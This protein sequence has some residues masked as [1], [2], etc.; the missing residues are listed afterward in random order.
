MSLEDWTP[1]DRQAV[2]WVLREEL[3][4][5]TGSREERIREIGNHL[6]LIEE[7]EEKIE[8]GDR[9]S[10]L[11]ALIWLKL[12]GAQVS[13]TWLIELC[14]E[15]Q[16]LR[17]AAVQVLLENDDVETD[18][19]GTELLL[20]DSEPMTLLGLDALY[21]MNFRNPEHLLMFTGFWAR[22]WGISKLVQVL[23]VMKTCEPPS[24]HVKAD[25]LL[26]FLEHDFPSVRAYIVEALLGY[27]QLPSEKPDQLA[28]DM[29]TEK[30]GFRYFNRDWHH[31]SQPF[32]SLWEQ[33]DLYSL[34]FDPSPKV[35]RATYRTLGSFG[36]IGSVEPVALALWWENNARAKV[37]SAESLYHADAELSSELPEDV[38]QTWRWVLARESFPSNQNRVRGETGE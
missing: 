26:E 22:E 13:P 21:R 3:L 15:D 30:S 28:S 38:R 18:M 17:S 23:R 16:E 32:P 5:S 31:P 24:R 8:E 9:Y 35:R 1:K 37:T 4:N 19:L 10:K 12:L 29:K 11:R 7:M 2:K 36:D 14:S 6:G 25:W 33:I 27:G 34:A 20:T